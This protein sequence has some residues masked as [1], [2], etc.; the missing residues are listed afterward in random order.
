[1]AT[2]WT[3]AATIL[4]PTL[5]VCGF[6]LLPFCLRHRVAL[7]AI[8]SPAM[9]KSK[10]MTAEHILAACRILSCTRLDVLR[11][12]TTM[13]EKYHATRMHY[14]QSYAVN[15]MLKLHYYFEAQS[16]WPRF[17][18]KEENEAARDYGT[19]WPLVI[20]ASLVRNG[21]T[22]EEAWTM[23][24]SQAVWLH[25]ANSQAAGA[26]INVITDKEWDAMENFRKNNKPPEPIK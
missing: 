9:D 23:P 5:E 25:I 21:F 15:E 13:S 12:K 22:S 8:E 26:K 24:E 17:W 11:D 3:Q 7:E 14:N 19:P 6:R 2:R 16:L 10:H 18:A 4:P 20:I 1:M